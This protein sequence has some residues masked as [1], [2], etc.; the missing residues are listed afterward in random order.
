MRKSHFNDEFLVLL[1]LIISRLFTCSNEEKK[2]KK[3]SVLAL[4]LSLCDKGAV[5][6]SIFMLSITNKPFML[7]VTNKAFLLS[8]MMLNVIM[9]SVAN[10]TTL[11]SIVTLNVIM[12]LLSVVMVI[13]VLLN[14]T[15]KA[16]LLSVVTLNVKMLSVIILNVVVPKEPKISSSSSKHQKMFFF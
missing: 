13:F 14:V 9:P 6:V 2:L 7:S 8:V 5:G 11:L 1:G 12:L 15:Y 16:I 4:V 3:Q 10:K